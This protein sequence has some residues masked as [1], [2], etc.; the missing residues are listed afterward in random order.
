MRVL[1]VDDSLAIRRTVR[2]ILD[3]YDGLEV[4]GDAE[5]GE[6][7]IERAAKLRPDL[8]IMDVSM[9]VLDG[10][11]AAEIIKKYHPEMRILMFSMHQVQEFVETAKRLGL[12]GYV[13]KD[14]AGPALRRAID[15]VLSNKT[16]F[17]A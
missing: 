3:G 9:P 6:E 11:S 2:S 8:I 16:Y 4:V 1:I 14:E 10:L 7:A 17:P 5:N 15:A 12:D 13:Q